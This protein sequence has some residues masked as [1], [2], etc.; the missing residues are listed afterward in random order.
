[1]T[2]CET[3]ATHK[4]S[5]S[6]APLCREHA[7]PAKREGALVEIRLSP[8]AGRRVQPSSCQYVEPQEAAGDPEP[9][10]SEEQPASGG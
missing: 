9:S 3:P 1:M 5:G 10:E 7:S 6:G 4:V 2:T 8:G